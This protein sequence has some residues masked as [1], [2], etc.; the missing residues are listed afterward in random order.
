MSALSE[1]FAKAKQA[2]AERTGDKSQ[3]P[4]VSAV[5][6]LPNRVSGPQHGSVTNMKMEMLKAEIDTLKAGKPSVLIDAREI[7]ASE[8]ANRL[9]DSFNTP[10]FAAHKKEISSAG[11]NK[12]PIKVRPISD[13]GEFK[14]EVVFGHRRHRACLELGIPVLAIVDS[15][16]DKH[17]FIEMDRENRAR[18]DLTPYEQGV[19]YTR[20]LEKGLFPSLRKMAEEIGEDASNVSKATS[21]AR[22]P[23]LVLDSFVSRLDIQYRWGAA[24]KVAIEKEPELILARA[25]DI[26][27]QRA[28]GTKISSQHAFDILVGKSFDSSKPVTKKVTVGDYV[29]LVTK[30]KK[31]LTFELPAISLE[32]Q[33]KIEK[34][35]A[36][37]LAK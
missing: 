1:K 2:M 22:L 33:G 18:E 36:D 26:A 13:S 31:K 7:R 3:V 29:L 30:S 35:I 15:L 16:D 25:A 5:L 24:L 27:K 34:Y 9:S 6:P 17:L 11:V 32:K 19:M 37:L 28:G 21:L 10:E 20:A 23:G 14:F 8:W 4:V 12:Q